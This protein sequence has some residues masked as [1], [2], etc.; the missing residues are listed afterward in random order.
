M[1]SPGSPSLEINRNRVIEIAVLTAALLVLIGISLCMPWL[2]V[3]FSYIDALLLG[4]ATVT[5]A[6]AYSRWTGWL[7]GMRVILKARLDGDGQ[8]WLLDSRGTCYLARLR[9]DSRLLGDILWLRFDSEHGI[10]QLILSQRSAALMTDAIRKLRVRLRFE[11]NNKQRLA[12][13][14]SGAAEQPAQGFR[15]ALRR[16]GFHKP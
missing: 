16:I 1:S 9:A 2:I 14:G 12:D 3:N 4:G 10:R 5:A 7:G 15:L 13:D 6:L 8:W 11:A